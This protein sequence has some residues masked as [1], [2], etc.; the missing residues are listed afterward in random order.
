MFATELNKLK[1]EAASKSLKPV[2]KERIRKNV[3]VLVD[4][5]KAKLATNAGG[6]DISGH[7]RVMRSEGQSVID[8]LDRRNSK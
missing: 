5:Y 7:V 4:R 6:R 2:S 8:M 3:E 1:I